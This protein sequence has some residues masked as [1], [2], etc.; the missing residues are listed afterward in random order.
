LEMMHYNGKPVRKLI[1]SWYGI[2]RQ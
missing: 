1:W 2:I